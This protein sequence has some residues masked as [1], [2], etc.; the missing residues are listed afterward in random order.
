MLIIDNGHG[1]STPGKCSPDGR[2]KEWLYTRRL[3]RAIAAKLEGMNIPCML[4]V[5]GDWD[6][7]LLSRCNRVNGIVRRYGDAVL[8][9]LH[10]NAAGNGREWCKASGWSVFVAPGAGE[11]SRRMAR[12]LYDEA[13]ARSVLGNRATPQGGYWEA[14]YAILRK[15]VCPAVLT[16]NMFHDNAADVGFLLSAGGFEIIVSLHVSGIARFIAQTQ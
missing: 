13:C 7:P 16:E 10:T 2:L 14:S 11:G 8:L 1:A 4:L 3:A 12:A 9:S 15:T 5:P 6:E